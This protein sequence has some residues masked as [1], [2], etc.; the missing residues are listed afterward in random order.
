[1]LIATLLYRVTGSCIGKI[2]KPIQKLGMKKY[3][4]NMVNDCF[5]LNTF[6]ENNAQAEVKLGQIGACLQ[7]SGWRFCESSI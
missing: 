5:F 3:M 2:N 6:E 1:M 7:D 4:K